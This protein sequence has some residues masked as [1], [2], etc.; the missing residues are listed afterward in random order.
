MTGMTRA[1]DFERVRREDVSLTEGPL[2]HTIRLH[3]EYAGAIEG[4]L[5]RLE[6][7]QIDLHWQA[8]GAQGLQSTSSSNVA[9]NT[10]KQRSR[11]TTPLTLPWDTSSRRKDSNGYHRGQSG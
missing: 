1:D 6:Y 7:I 11:R 5:G 2:G 10:A 3:G 8:K 4:I 9:G